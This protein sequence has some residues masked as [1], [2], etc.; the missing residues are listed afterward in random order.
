MELKMPSKKVIC[1][2]CNRDSPT[3]YINCAY[4]GKKLLPNTKAI[5]WVRGEQDLAQRF[6]LSESAKH[7][8]KPLEIDDGTNALMIVGSE[9]KGVLPPGSYK[10]FGNTLR[11]CGVLRDDET[12]SVIFIDVA[13]IAVP[14]KLTF[15]KVRTQDGDLVSVK[16]K[17]IARVTD[18]ID[19][20]QN[21]I[22]DRYS[23]LISELEDDWNET[24]ANII[25]VMTSKHSY[26]ELQGDGE[27]DKNLKLVIIS[28]MRE[29]AKSIG[30]RISR[31]DWISF[32]SETF[33]EDEDGLLD[34]IDTL[35]CSSCGRAVPADMIYCPFCGN[36]DFKQTFDDEF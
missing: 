32:E 19:F 8:K 30:I 9:C 13:E 17:L 2:T 1:G 10:E 33:A 14:Y 22:R 5:S 12:V 7:F 20:Y 16:G 27:V 4:C 35:E 23:M 29:V 3:S 15:D 11:K 26:S 21:Y 24:I 34:D 31:I 6:D 28:H 18:P 25:R 36:S